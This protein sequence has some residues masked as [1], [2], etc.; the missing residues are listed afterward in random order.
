MPLSKQQKTN[1]DETK[2]LEANKMDVCQIETRS[3]NKFLNLYGQMQVVVIP[4]MPH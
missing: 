4:V 3:F 1:K 2:W